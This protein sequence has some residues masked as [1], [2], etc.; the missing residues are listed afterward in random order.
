MH[1]CAD[2]MLVG[3]SGAISQTTLA[4]QGNAKQ[5]EAKE[6]KGEKKQEKESKASKYGSWCNAGSLILAEPA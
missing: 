1:V 5:S 3:T 6:N 4:Q 2:S